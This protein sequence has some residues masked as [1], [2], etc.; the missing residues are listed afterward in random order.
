VEVIRRSPKF[1]KMGGGGWSTWC[2]L[3]GVFV[4]CFGPSGVSSNLNLL[5]DREEV[6]KLLG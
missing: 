5:M 3:S 4:S 6:H 1:S 2:F